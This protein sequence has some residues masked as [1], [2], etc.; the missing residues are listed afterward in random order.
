MSTL[1]ACRADNFYR[2]HDYDPSKRKKEIEKKRKEG[3]LKLRKQ[4]A[5]KIRFEMPFHIRCNKCNNMIAKGVRFNAEKKKAGR[6]L[7]TYIFKFTMPCANC[8]NTLIIKTDPKSCEYLLVAGCVRYNQGDDNKDDKDNKEDKDDIDQDEEYPDDVV[9]IQS[10]E[11]G[12]KLNKNAFLKLETQKI[13]FN[14]GEEN[15]PRLLRL[16][17]SKEINKDDFYANR[18]MRRKLKI[19]KIKDRRAEEESRLKCVDI[20]LLPMREEDKVSK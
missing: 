16:L 11:E 7:G 3:K 2:P 14:K 20:K 5:R 6:Y 18:T 8:K 1:A 15:K 10:P 13:D 12:E 17:K 9:K 19:D 4:G